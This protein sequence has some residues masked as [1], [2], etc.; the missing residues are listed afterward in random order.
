MAELESEKREQA[1]SAPTQ[2]HE[3]VTGVKLVIIMTAISLVCLLMLL[4]VSMS[5][6]S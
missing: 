3:W 2:E 1:H 6:L 4:D 5:R